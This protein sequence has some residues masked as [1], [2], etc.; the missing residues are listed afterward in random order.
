M[1]PSQQPLP[2]L[3]MHPDHDSRATIKDPVCGMDVVPATAAGSVEHDGRTY[4]FCSRHCV[5]KFRADP[6]R[7]VRDDQSSND[8]VRV[9]S[10]PGILAVAQKFSDISAKDE[11]SLFEVPD[12]PGLGVDIS[13]KALQPYVT[14]STTIA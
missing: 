7:Y 5:D 8:L 13:E 11:F 1:D 9:E 14:A 3:P 4:Y 12:R 6:A 2:V 10:N